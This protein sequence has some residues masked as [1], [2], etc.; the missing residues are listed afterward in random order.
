MFLIT[1]LVLFNVRVITAYF[2]A[3]SVLQLLWP[4]GLISAK[5]SDQRVILTRKMVAAAL[6]KLKTTLS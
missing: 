4:L 6:I 5:N 3:L 2:T 1:R